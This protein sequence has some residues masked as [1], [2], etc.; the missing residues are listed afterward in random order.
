[1]GEKMIRG[2]VKY[3]KNIKRNKNIG[4]A[5]KRYLEGEKNIWSGALN[6]KYWG[7]NREIFRGTMGEKMIR[8]R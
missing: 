8:G 4:G 6:K 7:V 5:N 2:L 1:M 3:K